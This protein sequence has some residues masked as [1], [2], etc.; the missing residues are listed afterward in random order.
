MKKQM[1]NITRVMTLS[2]LLGAG[3]GFFQTAVAAEWPV[4]GDFGKGAQLWVENCNRC[5]SY[6]DPQELRDDQWITSIFHMRIRAGLTGQQA[7]DLVTF[8]QTSNK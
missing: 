1:T 8:M 6:R 7:R 2:V 3:S 5:H 4:K